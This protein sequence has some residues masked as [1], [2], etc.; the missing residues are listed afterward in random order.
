VHEVDIE[1]IKRPF[2][3][4][5]LQRIFAEESTGII[6]IEQ[7]MPVPSGPL[8]LAIAF[9]SKEPGESRSAFPQCRPQCRLVSS[10][11][12]QT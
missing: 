4:Q 10:G 1:A 2:G 11:G 9:L 7:S 5:A 8:R 12:R 6:Q 3:L